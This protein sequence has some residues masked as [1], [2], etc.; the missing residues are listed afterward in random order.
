MNSR[1]EARKHFFTRN[2]TTSGSEDV[3][4]SSRGVGLPDISNNVGHVKPFLSS[5]LSFYLK[6][7]FSFVFLLALSSL[8][9]RPRR[10]CNLSGGF[11]PTQTSLRSK[12]RPCLLLQIPLSGSEMP[13]HLD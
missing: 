7:F 8:Y 13:N 10:V 6:E 11:S 1:R 4:W 2:L 5:L 12:L 9:R 3:F